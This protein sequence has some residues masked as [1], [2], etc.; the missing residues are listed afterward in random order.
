M[1]GT[2][3]KEETRRYDHN[4]MWRL[5]GKTTEKLR[6]G[7]YIGDNDKFN[8]DGIASSIDRLLIS[9]TVSFVGIDSSDRTVGSVGTR[10]IFPLPWYS[11]IKA[12]AA[13]IF[14][15]YTIVVSKLFNMTSSIIISACRLTS[16]SSNWANLT[17]C[18]ANKLFPRIAGSTQSK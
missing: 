15:S 10:S 5:S 13:L 14:S 18:T 17:Q 6:L 8:I 2:S 3:E 1:Q 12:S 7:M 9:D 11:S 16:L 4:C